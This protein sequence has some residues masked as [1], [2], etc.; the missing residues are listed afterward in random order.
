MMS[1]SKIG[2][3]ELLTLRH[4][5]DSPE[6]M[7]WKKKNDKNYERD[8]YYDQMMMD[9]MAL[10]DTTTMAYD[11]TVSV[12]TTMAPVEE[13]Y[14]EDS[15]PAE[16][17]LLDTFIATGLLPFDADVELPYKKVTISF[18]KDCT[19][20]LAYN[21]KTEK[22]R[23]KFYLN[24]SA[25]VL[26]N[27]TAGAMYCPIYIYWDYTGGRRNG[28]ASITLTMALPGEKEIKRVVMDMTGPK[29]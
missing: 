21:G 18:Y 19:Y 13:P 24:R 20:T 14:I 12:E 2:T 16:E 28:I 27:T 26:Q 11:T 9:T 1:L 10:A 15:R 23:F 6:E 3:G 8:M 25:I 5:Y 7:V 17:L 22:G 29:K 4:S